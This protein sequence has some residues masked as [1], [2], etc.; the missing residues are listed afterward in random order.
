MY[1]HT[2]I[3]IWNFR[4]DVLKNFLEYDLFCFN[5]IVAFCIYFSHE[6]ILLFFGIEKTPF[7]V[8]M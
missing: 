4:Y 8:H 3:D 5:V 7:Y 6:N 1:S 2:Q